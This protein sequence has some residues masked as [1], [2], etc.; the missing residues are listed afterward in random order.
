MQW[1]TKKRNKNNPGAILLDNA[2]VTPAVGR[3]NLV[4]AN[5]LGFKNYKRLIKTTPCGTA[6]RCTI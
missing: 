4:E 3:T 5:G 2:L 1:K 6:I